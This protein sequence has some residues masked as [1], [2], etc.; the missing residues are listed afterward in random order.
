MFQE[1]I[2]QDTFGNPDLKNSVNYNVDLRWE[3]FPSSSE[4]ISLA[5]FGKYIEDPINTFLVVSAANDLSYANTGDKATAFGAELDIR[6]NIIDNE[7]EVAE[8]TLRTKL[9]VGG[10]ISYLN[11][12]QDLDAEKVSETQMDLAAAFTNTEAPLQG[13][14]DIIVNADIS[15]SKE[16][17]ADRNISSTVV[18]NYFSDRIY[19]I[20]STGRG[21]LVDRGY[22]TLDWI[23]KIEFNEHI[24][25]GLNL[26]NILN[27]LVERVNENAEGKLNTENPAV[28]G[29]L[30]NGQLP[31]CH[32]KKGLIFA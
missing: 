2:N 5:V 21:H 12:N 8:N 28:T 24:S 7:R 18:G 22:I 31:C 32:T 3:L 23:S 25:L 9:A 16:L 10:N 4:I 27:P 6:K 19:A 30:T 29:F 26:Q 13:A 1:E 20:G 11:T 14:S 17:S 15:F